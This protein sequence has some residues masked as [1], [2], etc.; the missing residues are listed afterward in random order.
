MLASR[1]PDVRQSG[2]PV[3]PMEDVRSMKDDV[4]WELNVMHDNL[5]SI[6]EYIIKKPYCR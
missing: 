4:G 2:H 1:Y 5:A 3:I 6:N